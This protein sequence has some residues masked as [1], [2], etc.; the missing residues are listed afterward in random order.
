MPTIYLE[1]EV[2]EKLEALMLK[3]LNKRIHEPKIL[4]SAIKN[5]YGYT[6]SEF[7]LKLVKLGENSYKRG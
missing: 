1:P 3:E 2:K 6:H 7:I 4:I 5:K